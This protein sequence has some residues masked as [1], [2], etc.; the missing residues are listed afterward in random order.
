[1]SNP[2]SGGLAAQ[3]LNQLQGQPLEQM[4]QQLDVSPAQAGS[5]VSA[6]LPMMLGALAGNAQTAGGAQAL[7]G[8]LQR[9]HAGG[10]ADLGGL[11][12]GVLGSVLGGG[13]PAASKQ[14]DASGILGHV[15]GSQQAQAQ[16]Q[17]GQASGL[18]SGQAGQLLQMLA[19]IVMGFLA[20]QVGSAKLDA[21]G[22][23]NLL[24]GLL[25]QGGQS[26]PQSGGLAGGL[27]SSALDQNGDGK[28][29]A[30]DLL[31]LGSRLLGGK[32]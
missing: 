11:L 13:Q 2:S 12:G 27:P 4:A 3:L 9:D 24:G 8:A 17:I 20:K 22:L 32:S 23:G 28:L 25:G 31:K 29:D 1:M 14:L 19:P 15:F 6:A 10:G 16:N 30:G 26:Q 7:L 21:G 18:S 5:A